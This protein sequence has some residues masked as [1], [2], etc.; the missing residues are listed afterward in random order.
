MKELLRMN[1]LSSWALLWRDDRRTQCIMKEEA[2]D[3]SMSKCNQL[4]KTPAIY[5]S[6]LKYVHDGLLHAPVMPA[7]NCRLTEKTNQG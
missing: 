4:H 5:I 2:I 3:Q 7:V 6:H 1:E